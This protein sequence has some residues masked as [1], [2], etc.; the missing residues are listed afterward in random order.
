MNGTQEADLNIARNA[1]AIIGIGQNLICPTQNKGM[2]MELKDK[3]ELI[4]ALKSFY[5]WNVTNLTFFLDSEGNW[6]CGQTL[7]TQI[8]SNFAMIISNDIQN[9]KKFVKGSFHK[10]RIGYRLCLDVWSDKAETQAKIIEG[11]EDNINKHIEKNKEVKNA[12]NTQ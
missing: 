5:S 12:I 3:K 11:L 8:T 2:I 1:E 7:H 4:K 9:L 10:F 6:I